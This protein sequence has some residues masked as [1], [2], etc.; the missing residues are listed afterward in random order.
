MTIGRASTRFGIVAIWFMTV[1]VVAQPV[2]AVSSSIVIS[3]VQATDTKSAKNEIIELQN[4]TDTAVDISNWSLTNYSAYGD[5]SMLLTRFDTANSFTHLLFPS[6]TRELIVSN[7]YS[8]QYSVSGATQ[9]SGGMDYPGGALI[10]TNSLGLSIDQVAWGTATANFET[11]PAPAMTATTVLK[12]VQADSDDNSVDFELADQSAQDYSYGN[13]YEIDDVC[14]NLDGIQPVVPEGMTRAADGSC[15]HP[16]VCSNVDGVQAIIPDGMYFDDSG[17]CVSVDVCSN[18]DGIQGI[19]PDGYE[20]VGDICQPIFVPAD[21]RLNEL[22]PNPDG[23]D[24]GNEFIEIYNASAKPVSLENYWIEI[25][26]KI[27]SFPTGSSIDGQSYK[28]FSDHDMS[29]V[30]ANGVGG[31]VGL[32]AQGAGQI[33]AIPNYTG[34]PIDVSWALIDRAWQYTNRPT[35]GADNLASLLDVPSVDSTATLAPCAPNQYR[36]PDTNHCKLIASASSLAPCKDGQYRSEETNRCRSIVAKV[37][38]VLKPCADDQFRN[39]ATGRCKKIATAED[40]LQP[41]NSGYERNLTTNRCRKVQ[42]AAIPIADFPVEPITNVA[43]SVSMWWALGGVAAAGGA[44][45]VWEWREEA[46]R[47]I[48]KVPKFFSSHK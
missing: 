26:G 8:L 28:A 14:S 19:A 17:D 7:E 34:A 36:N 37:S 46:S 11:A 3:S 41:C 44:Y 2:D 13:L 33:D 40:I 45:G 15:N 24:A 5:M 23:A 31:S 22:L 25:A 43:Q 16:D 10:L 42:T 27:Y 29:V 30:F 47:L 18:L 21:L 4:P 9:F 1:I 12:R 20:K 48:R 32:Y 35:P 39:P 38:A 6:Q